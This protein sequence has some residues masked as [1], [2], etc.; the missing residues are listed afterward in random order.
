VVDLSG[1][2]G[3]LEPLATPE[4]G[5]PR[6]IGVRAFLV[7]AQVNSLARHHRGHLVEVARVINAWSTAQRARLVVTGHDPA[8][9]YHPAD[10]LFNKLCEVLDAG[11]VAGGVALDAKWLANRLALASVPRQFL[12]SSSLAVDGTDIETWGALHGD[13]VTVDLDGEAVETQLMDEGTVPK[14]RKPARKA[15]VLGVGPDGRKR[16][17]V[18]P[19]A[20]AGHR[21]ATNSRPAGPYVGYELHLGAQ[22]REMRW[23]NGVDKTTLSEEVP[24]VVTCLSLVPAGTHRGKAIVDDLVAAKQAGRAIDDVIWDPG[25]SLCKPGTVHH[26]LAEAGVHQTF[27][28]SPSSVASGPPQAM[29]CSSTASSSHRSCPRACGSCLRPR[30]GQVKQK[31]WPTKRTSTSA[32]AGG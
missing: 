18:D 32:R 15:Q 26:K 4:V 7:A 27:N 11:H 19:D 9:T 16:Y 21:S 25:Y 20:R 8:Q 5:R 3:L 2:V 29:R 1:V 24:G 6:A 30:E 31:S 23:T 28:P 17:T 12:R 22:A 10:R 14:P 13:P